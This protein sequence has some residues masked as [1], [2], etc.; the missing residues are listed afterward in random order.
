MEKILEQ[1]KTVVAPHVLGNV[2]ARLNGTESD[3]VK[4]AIIHEEI[5][6]YFTGWQNFFH[7]YLCFNENQRRDFSELMYDMVLPLAQNHE[8]VA[9]PVY[10][11]FVKETGKTGAR[12]FICHQPV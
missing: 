12:E 11:K 8:P 10:E 9:N 3:E 7:Q 2:K 5:V 1:F 4:L 6:K